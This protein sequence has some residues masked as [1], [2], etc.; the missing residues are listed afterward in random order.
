MKPNVNFNLLGE[1]IFGSVAMSYRGTSYKIHSL[2]SPKRLMYTQVGMLFFT[3]I[4]STVTICNNVCA[5]NDT[6]LLF[7]LKLMMIC[8]EGCIIKYNY[9]FLFL[10][11]HFGDQVCHCLRGFKT[12]IVTIVA[13]ICKALI[14]VKFR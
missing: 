11:Q 7:I 13:V 12:F 6:N 4:F 1:M 2:Q 10:C 8:H 14:N 5:V 9:K 3:C